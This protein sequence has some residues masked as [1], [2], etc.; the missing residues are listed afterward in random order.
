MLSEGQKKK[1]K[2]KQ[3]GVSTPS[4]LQSQLQ[5]PS[6]TFWLKTYRPDTCEDSGIEKSPAQNYWV[7]LYL[8]KALNIFVTS[9]GFSLGNNLRWYWIFY[10][11]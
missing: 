9:A 5:F 2:G 7:W 11:K 3:G 10:W 4:I 1:K 8:R 6:V